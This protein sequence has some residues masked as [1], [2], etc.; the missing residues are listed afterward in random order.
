MD[1]IDRS[2]YKGGKEASEILGVHQRTLYLWDA[3]GIIETIRTPGNKRLYN[4]TKYLNDHKKKEEIKEEIIE[5]NN[6]KIIYV[7]VS[8]KSQI[9]DLERQKQYMKKKYPK[10]LLIED[11]GSGINLNRRGLNKIIKL[12]IAGKVKEL[13]VAYKDRL[14][15][16]GYDLIENLIKEY[17]GGKII[18]LNQLKVKEP[19]E[20]LVEDMLQIMNIYVAKMNGLRKYSKKS[21]N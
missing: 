8:S 19:Q 2:N 17:S 14:A 18:I 21:K 9:N 12:A 16:F 4:V 3:K 15:R 20:E 10:H 1:K 13:V 5:E 11:I 7:R 6:L